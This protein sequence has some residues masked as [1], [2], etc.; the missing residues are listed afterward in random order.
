MKISSV[1]LWYSILFS[2]PPESPTVAGWPSGFEINVGE[3]L[4]LTCT[5]DIL[6]GT[7]TR[8]EWYLGT[9]NLTS[10]GTMGE[11]YVKVM[12]V[13]DAGDYKCLAMNDA[14]DA[15]SATP[16][17]TVNGKL[18]WF[19]SI[20]I[21]NCGLYN[22]RKQYARVAAKPVTVVNH[23]NYWPDGDQLTSKSGRKRAILDIVLDLFDNTIFVS[24]A[25]VCMSS[26]SLVFE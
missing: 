18:F 10:S 16:T 6:G 11:N 2:D 9:T 15:A 23:Q 4:N 13:S 8:F 12:D 25:L 22:T 14:G 19:R 24:K 21:S 17:I 3:T 1:A 5:A 20:S 7:P 26:I